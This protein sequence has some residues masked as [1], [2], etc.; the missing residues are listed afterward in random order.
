MP[1]KN[2]IVKQNN[3]TNIHFKEITESKTNFKKLFYFIILRSI[4]FFS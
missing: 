2:K 1:E 4:A 3:K